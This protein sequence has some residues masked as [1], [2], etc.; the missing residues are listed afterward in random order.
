M[1]RRDFIRR[2]K[3]LGATNAHAAARLVDMS[4]SHVH[5]VWTG[6]RRV[7]PVM[8]ERLEAAEADMEAWRASQAM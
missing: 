8:V 5:R 6:E 1:T 7:G 3:A 4:H 2:C